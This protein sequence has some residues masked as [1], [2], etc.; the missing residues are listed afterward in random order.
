VSTGEI[1]ST[2]LGHSDRVYLAVFSADDRFIVT[3]S[4][5]RTARVWETETGRLLATLIGHS[6]EVFSAAFSANGRQVITASRDGTARVWDAGTGVSRFEIESDQKSLV[7]AAFADGGESIVTLD[8]NA[9]ARRWNARSGAPLP[10]AASVGGPDGAED[11]PA[12]ESIDALVERITAG[13]V[14]ITGDSVVSPRGTYLVT[15][16]FHFEGGDGKVRV[17]NVATGLQLAEVTPSDSQKSVGVVGISPDEGLIATTEYCD[18]V[19]DCDRV[20]TLRETVTGTQTRALRGHG[21]LIYH[22]A[23]DPSGKVLVTSDGEGALRVWQVDT[24]NLMAEMR[25]HDDDARIAFSPDSASFV[26][27]GRDDTVQVYH[28]ESCGSLDAL[29][30]RAVKRSVRSLSCR[31]RR[32]YIDEEAIC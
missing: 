4:A 6:D 16:S 32:S 10:A 17:W 24:G 11:R 18:M 29:V 8:E 7:R 20:V 23:F 5:D 1:S 25:G 28:C 13:G 30:D 26:T 15:Q 3:A 19:I 12:A 22:A 21:N 14:A 2:L 27:V 31:E 9:G